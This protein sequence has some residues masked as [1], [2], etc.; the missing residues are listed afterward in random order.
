MKKAILLNVGMWLVVSATQLNAQ[1]QVVE[2]GGNQAPSRN[3]ETINSAN[4]GNELLISLYNQLEALQQEMQTLRGLVEEQGHEVK[5]LQTETRERYLDIDRR[6]I[7]MSVAGE[8]PNESVST[9]ANAPGTTSNTQLGDVRTTVPFNPVLQT[10]TLPE[11][12]PKQSIIPSLNVDQM[13]EQDLYRTALNLL[14]EEGNNGDAI[15]LFQRY[16]ERFP[17]GRL[18]PNALYW[19]GE[20]YILVARYPQARDVFEHVLRDYPEDPKAAGAMLKLGV[21]YNLMGERA[22]AEQT[23]REIAISY[24][25]SASENALA[26]DYISRL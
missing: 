11:Q 17:D 5:R 20:A 23:W 14:L 6:I 13:T 18:L 16:V 22:L 10:A 1:V 26:K 7:A 25:D 9:A 4:S 24:P 21:A 3:R 19:Q 8:D 12:A 2:A 15:S